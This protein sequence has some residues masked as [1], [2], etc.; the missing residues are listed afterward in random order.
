MKERYEPV[1]ITSPEEELHA[2]SSFTPEDL[3]RIARTN[4]ALAEE[5]ASFVVPDVEI[6]Y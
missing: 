2:S 6:E 1:D 3:E 4:S 5:I